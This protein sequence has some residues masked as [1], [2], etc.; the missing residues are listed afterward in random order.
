MYVVGKVRALVSICLSCSKEKFIIDRV[1]II[2]STE[3][4]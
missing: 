3:A 4:I 2:Y 1:L